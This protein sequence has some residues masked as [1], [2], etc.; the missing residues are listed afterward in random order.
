MVKKN[1]EQ[2]SPKNIEKDFRPTPVLS[3]LAIII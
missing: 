3:H 1:E 2:C